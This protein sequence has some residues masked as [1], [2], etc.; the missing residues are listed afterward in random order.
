MLYESVDEGVIPARTQGYEIFLMVCELRLGLGE[1]LPI[2]NVI[3]QAV[4]L[5]RWGLVHRD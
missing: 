2:L 3:S 4:L 5:S 1:A